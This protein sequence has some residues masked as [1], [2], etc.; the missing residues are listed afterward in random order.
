M[1]N[2][3]ASTPAP[4]RGVAPFFAPLQREFDRVLADFSSFDL[5]DVFGAS[6]RMDMRETEGA[7][8]LTV[9][10]PGMTEDEIHIDL[11][12]DVLTVSG[13]KKSSAET[14]DKGV[15][16]VER[17]YGSFSRSVRLPGAV[18]A[19]GIKASLKQGVLTVTAPLDAG[20]VARKIPIPIKSA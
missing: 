13:E 9:E 10:L 15:R 14:H 8:E 3:P 19:D 5:S 6:P 11:E 4:V 2:K 17:R 1:N 18:K 16:M 20:A 12:D 7:V